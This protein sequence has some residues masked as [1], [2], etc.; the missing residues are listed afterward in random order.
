M[1]TMCSYPFAVMQPTGTLDDGQEVVYA[2]DLI[3][4]VKVISYQFGAPYRHDRVEPLSATDNTYYQT[5]DFHRVRELYRHVDDGKPEVLISG[6]ENA[7]RSEW[8]QWNMKPPLTYDELHRPSLA[9][10]RLGGLEQ[11]LRIWLEKAEPRY[12]NDPHYYP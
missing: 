3:S 1:R 9:V 6:P 2:F 12:R 4:G 11:A 10:D 7:W 8:A 5:T